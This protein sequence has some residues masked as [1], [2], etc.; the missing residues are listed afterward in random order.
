MDELL[1]DIDIDWS[2]RNY[3]AVVQE[4][5]GP[6]SNGLT[7]SD[8]NLINGKM[9]FDCSTIDADDETPCTDNAGLSKFV[10]RPGKTHRL[11][12]IN[13]GAEGTQRISIDGHNMTVIANDFVPIKPYDT[14]VITLGVGQRT[15]VIVHAHAD[16]GS[17]FWLRAN[18]TSCS[19]TKQPLA[20]AAIYYQGAD[21]T[22]V[23]TSTPW[24]VPDPGTCENDD[25][26]LTVPYY[27]VAL[28]EP[29]WTQHMD[30]SAY[31]NSSGS[32][33]WE[34]GVSI[35]L[36]VII[37]GIVVL[38][39]LQQGVA[40]RVDYNNPTLLQARKKG[41]FQ[42]TAESNLINYGTNSSIRI[43]I[44]NPARS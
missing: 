38:H 43:I 28:P 21:N 26:A 7:Y 12:F 30:V 32:F 31:I 40:A 14:Q 19:S 24:D 34:F 2:H 3:Y 11:R 25:L 36:Y 13:S 17:A 10:F 20:L 35:F 37:L 8:N 33:L 6:G 39:D 22:S 16:P 5:M 4:I 9:N 42:Y 15:D 41:G 18:M 44:N 29:S 27:P 23:P 1:I